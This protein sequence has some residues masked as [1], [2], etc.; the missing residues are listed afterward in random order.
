MQ[1]A[2]TLYRVPRRPGLQLL[3]KRGSDQARELTGWRLR[4]EPGASATYHSDDE[5]TVV[6]LQDGA[7]KM[8]TSAGTWDVSRKSVFDERASALYLPPKAELKVTAREPFEAVLISTPAEGGGKPALV[9]PD[10][11]KVAAR[12]KSIYSREIHDIFVDDPHTRRLIVG[13]TFNPAGNWS[14]YPPHKHDGG[15]G[16]PRLEEVY[17]FRVDHP[18]GFGYH[19]IYTSQGESVTHAVRDGDT[20]LIPYGYHPVAAAPGYRVYYLWAL[21]GEVH[22]LALYMDPEH[23]WLQ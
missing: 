14:S 17:H 22:R 16:E 6:V 19:T 8:A 15:N 13:E 11:V 5:E 23:V 7:G 21:S 12:G 2:D 20:V 1:L 18:Q 3:H 9:G 4:L 10:Q